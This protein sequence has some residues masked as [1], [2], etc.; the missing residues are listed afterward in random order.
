MIRKIVTAEDPVL[1][2]KSKPIKKVDKKV[3]DLIK[4]LQDTLNAKKDPEG[5][6]LAAP[7][8]GVLKRVFVVKYKDLPSA[9]VNPKIVSTKGP[10][11]KK[12]RKNKEG[13]ML[14]GCLSIPQYY[15]PLERSKYVK[16]EFT[17]EDG[18][19]V[20][21]EVTGF[22]AQII[23]HEVDHLDGVLYVD[24]I[25]KQKL[26]LYKQNTAGEWEEVEL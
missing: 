1:R 13:K 4:D 12:K 16:F 15:S 8:I 11:T 9:F 24:H 6:G 17:T 22:G 2:K 20:E 21:Q 19:R 25:L 10:K 7:Q 3:K 14:E 23:Q 18:D 5:V 26:P